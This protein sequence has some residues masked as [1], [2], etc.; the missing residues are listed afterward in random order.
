MCKHPVDTTPKVGKSMQNSGQKGVIQKGAAMARTRRSGLDDNDNLDILGTTSDSRVQVK[1]SKCTNI[2]DAENNNCGIMGSPKKTLVKGVT[3]EVWTAEHFNVLNDNVKPQVIIRPAAAGS[4]KTGEQNL[5]SLPH[6]SRGRM[7]RKS[8]IKSPVQVS[9]AYAGAK[10]SEPPS[11][12]VLPKPPMH[13]MSTESNSGLWNNCAEI[14][15]V[16]KVMLKVQS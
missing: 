2:S 12:K 9:P 5:K 14:T 4:P 3:Y 10:F 1:R 7:S 8:P 6:K 15:N 11:P 16:L 13:W